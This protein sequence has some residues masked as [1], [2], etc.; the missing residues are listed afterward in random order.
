MTMRSASTRTRRAFRGLL[1]ALAATAAGAC[2]TASASPILNLVTTGSLTMTQGTAGTLAISVTN[3]G[4]SAINLAGLT[5]GLQLVPDGVTTGSLTF[6]DF[7]D[8]GTAWTNPSTTQPVLDQ[9]VGPLNGTTEYFRMSISGEYEFQPS[10]TAVL[11]TIEFTASANALGTWQLWAVN[12]WATGGFPVTAVDDDAFGQE[13]FTNLLATEGA[14]PG[15]TL[16]IGSV[17]VAPVPEPSA[18]AIVGAAVAVLGGVGVVRARR[19]RSRVARSA[20]A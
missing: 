19:A 17:T 13:Q 16:Q 6:G 2:G 8:A 12:E 15:V 20:D 18:L 11:G 3:T 9:L 4:A 7:F 10:T 5:I 14:D 1:M